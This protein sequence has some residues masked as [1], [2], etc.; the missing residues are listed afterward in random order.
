MEVVVIQKE[1][2]VEVSFVRR[3][4]LVEHICP[5]CE[6]VFLAPRL[7]V[8]CTDSC[9][10]KAAWGRHG[11]EWNENKKQLR[12]QSREANQHKGSEE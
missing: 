5:T 7:R 1:K 3:Y 8:Y 4:K 10:Q 9:K 12:T 11:A 2:S 6:T